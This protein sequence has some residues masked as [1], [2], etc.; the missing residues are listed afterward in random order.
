MRCYLISLSLILLVFFSGTTAFGLQIAEVGPRL[1]GYE[2]G[3]PFEEA[4]AL[5]GFH[6]VEPIASEDDATGDY[7]AKF[8]FTDE[9]GTVFR[10]FVQ[11]IDNH[12]E[13]ILLFFTAPQMNKIFT[14]LNAAFGPPVT[15]SSEKATSIGFTL[16][17][18]FCTWQTMGGYQVNLTY[19][20]PF[21]SSRQ[22]TQSGFVQMVSESYR[23][24]RQDR[25]ISRAKD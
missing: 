16:N 15:D 4:V 1:L 10:G 5:H 3:M 23:I 11:F 24:Y 2:I 9:D 12:A 22:E 14:S 7:C 21:D 6:Q 8:R 20:E 25:R 13:K 19:T 18:R 17:G